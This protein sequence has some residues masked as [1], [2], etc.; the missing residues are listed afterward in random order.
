MVAAAHQF[1]RARAPIRTFARA[2]PVTALPAALESEE[3]LDDE[4]SHVSV[5]TVQTLAGLEG[6]VL[7]VGSG[8]KIGPSL[9]LTAQRGLR[10]AG[11]AGHVIAVSRFS[12]E[13]VRAHLAGQG[14]ET[15]SAD[16][17]EPREISALP[18]APNVIYLLG[19]KFGTTGNESTTWA[20][21]ALVAGMVAERYAG[22]RLVV[23]SSGNVYPLT[24]TIDGGATEATPPGPVGEYAQSCL[25]RERLFEDASRRHA[26]PTVIL[27]LNYA[28]A[29][30]Y[31]V[32]TD[33]GL[34][35]H[36]GEAVDLSMGNVN[37]IWQGDV[38]EAALRALAL[39]ESPP[40]VLNIAGPETVSVRWLAEQF[41]ERFGTRPAYR[42]VAADTA[43]LSNAAR[44]TDRFGYP[45][46]PLLRMIDWTA[47]WIERGGRLLGKP[48]HFQ[49]RAGAF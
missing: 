40:L 9:A 10:A 37:V 41:A 8:G 1:V 2:G 21:N 14:I 26:S 19:T 46:V 22:S 36:R 43:L 7:L 4:L 11:A 6:D 16:L 33:I 44:A 45:R 18:D 31:G 48:T 24:P 27:R 49:E 29:L 47:Q 13:A 15:V 30:T 38:N 20:V 23:F 17:R 3:E 39:G 28:N 35:V 34:A 12:D 32:L 5:E 25:A 42:G